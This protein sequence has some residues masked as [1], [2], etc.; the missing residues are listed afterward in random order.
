MSVFFERFLKSNKTKVIEAVE[1]AEKIQEEISPLL[2]PF[3]ELAVELATNK[4]NLE[5][6]FDNQDKEQ[7]KFYLYQRRQTLSH[8]LQPRPV[9][10]DGEPKEFF[11]HQQAIHHWSSCDRRD[12]S[13]YEVPH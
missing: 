10:R 9:G 4:K 2:K 3:N 8:R 1:T 13:A 5:R 12:E 11:P 7:I 6:A